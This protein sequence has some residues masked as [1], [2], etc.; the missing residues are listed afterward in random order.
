VHSDVQTCENKFVLRGI[1]KSQ[2]GLAVLQYERIRINLIILIINDLCEFY[3]VYLK[4]FMHMQQVRVYD[5]R[6]GDDN[7]NSLLSSD[8]SFI[9]W[10]AELFVNSNNGDKIFFV[11]R[12]EKEAFL[13]EVTSIVVTGKN[14]PVLDKCEI[15]YDGREYWV[16]PDTQLRKLNLLQTATITAGWKWKH[17]LRQNRLA[18]LWKPGECISTTKLEK[19]NDLKRL[20]SHGVAYDILE[21]CCVNTEKVNITVNKKE[22]DLTVI[23]PVTIKPRK[24]EKDIKIISDSITFEHPYRQMLMALKTKPFV[25]LA[26]ISGIGKSSL[27]RKLAYLTCTEKELQQTDRPRNFHL[28][29]VKVDWCDSSDLLGYHIPQG[30]ALKYNSTD[31]MRFMV[32]AW[33]YTHVP[34][35]ACLDEMNLA[36]IEHYFAEFLSIL[37]TARLQNG[38]LQYDTFLSKEE[39]VRCSREDPTFWWQLGVEDGSLLQ[40]QFL[41]NGISMPP[42]LAVIGTVNMDET[43]HLLSRRV[44]DRAM[45]IEMNEVD[46]YAGLKAER[47]DWQYPDEFPVA[48]ILTQPRINYTEAYKKNPATSARI[49]QELMKI[50]EILVNS[51]FRFAYRVRNEI[52][53]Y[54]AYNEALN[55]TS[56]LPANW[57]NSC[58]DE[59]FMMKILSRIEGDESQCRDIIEQLYKVTVPYPA[60][61]Q[62]LKQMLQ[63]VNQGAYT[64]FW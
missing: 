50:N 10:A 42:N 60:C 28:I 35:F 15:V 23:T 21:N 26:G 20:F 19:I 32:K 30:G 51:P 24:R 33:K 59:I 47:E 37:E 43:S 38:V 62:K 63:K 11:N 48:T 55:S 36:R 61:Q 17:S 34:F 52:L 3:A 12:E 29:K 9:L 4:K 31:L 46:L 39:V 18:D 16:K 56:Q 45:V 25:L 14:N 49:M 58:L 44:L 41:E 64:L 5:V 13:A 22:L 8:K 53:I 7:Y 2:N 40:Q 6:N 1:Y 27:V 57:L 54:C